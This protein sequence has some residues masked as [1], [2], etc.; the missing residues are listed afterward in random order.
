MESSLLD[1]EE[2]MVN[3]RTQVERTFQQWTTIQSDF[4][5]EAANKLS[6]R[7]ARCIMKGQTDDEYERLHIDNEEV[8]ARNSILQSE[9][10]KQK[11]ENEQNKS[12]IVSLTTCNICEHEYNSDRFPCKL[13]C[14]HIVCHNCA[15]WWLETKT[16]KASCPQCREPYSKNDIKQ[17]TL[18]I[19]K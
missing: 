7:F 8:K 2:K 12:T 3:Y 6:L 5:K 9:L 10:A 19:Q 15:N 14:S 4:V 11:L 18:A 1:Q 13:R 16:T 17:I